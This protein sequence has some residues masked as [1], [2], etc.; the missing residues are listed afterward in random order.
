MIKKIIVE[1]DFKLNDSKT[2]IAGSSRAKIVTGLVLTGDS[3]GIGRKKFKNVRSKI[4]H[5]VL[6]SSH[7]NIKLF[8]EVRGWLAYLK[9]VD[10]KRFNKAKKYIGELNA[11][12]PG[13]LISMLPKM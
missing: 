6:P 2:R 7:S 13:T 4:F 3:F 10:E 5:L 9:S 11:K 1:E 12:Y 8:E